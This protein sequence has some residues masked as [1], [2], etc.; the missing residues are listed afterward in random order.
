MINLKKLI[1]EAKQVKLHFRNVLPG[2]IEADEDIQFSVSVYNDRIIYIP[3]TSKDLDKIDSLNY[4]NRDSLGDLIAV[5]INRQFK[6]IELK[7]D[8]TYVGAGFGFVVDLE[9]ILKK[10]K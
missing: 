6:E 1:V 2:G 7:Y 10:I 4:T 9:K 3:K 8:D 5:I